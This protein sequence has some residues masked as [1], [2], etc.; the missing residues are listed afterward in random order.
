MEFDFASSGSKFKFP[1]LFE[2]NWAE[3]SS[4]CWYKFSGRPVSRHCEELNSGDGPAQGSE[5]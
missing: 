4:T 5:A 1:E 2:Y 3:V